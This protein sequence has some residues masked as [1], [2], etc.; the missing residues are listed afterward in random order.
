[1]Q[2]LGQAASKAD[3]Y[4][5]EAEQLRQAL[6]EYGNE[7]EGYEKQLQAKQIEAG[8]LESEAKGLRSALEETMRRLREKNDESGLIDKQLMIQL[9][10]N[11]FKVKGSGKSEVLSAISKVL[12][13]N[14]EEQ[15]AVGLKSGGWFSW[16]GARESGASA[17][18]H[19]NVDE[20]SI[21]DLFQQFL[22]NDPDLAEDD[23][24]K[25]ALPVGHRLAKDATNPTPANTPLK[26]VSIMPSSINPPPTVPFAA[27][28]VGTVQPSMPPSQL[29]PEST[30]FPGQNTS[31]IPPPAPDSNAVA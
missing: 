2:Q 26:Q 4:R 20:D 19:V 6:A 18:Q 7:K 25:K 1:M 22:L 23:A 3:G 24:K 14:D 28:P 9:F 11:Y 16:F 8:K 5:A 15:V 12:E 21:G 31:Q 17:A 30:P 27:A 10:V 29:V 13:F